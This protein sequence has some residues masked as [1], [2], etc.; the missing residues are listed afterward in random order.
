MKIMEKMKFELEK[1]KKT[2]NDLKKKNKELVRQS[3][4]LKIK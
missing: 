4:I 3:S 2:T 1:S